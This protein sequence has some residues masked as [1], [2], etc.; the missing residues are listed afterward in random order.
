MSVS[1]V[2]IVSIIGLLSEL[3]KV[4]K[5]CGESQVFHPDNALSFYKNTEKFVPLSDKNPYSAPLSKINEALT[6]AGKSIKTV[7]VHNFDVTTK[8]INDY[9][10]YL[11]KKLGMLS[12]EKSSLLQKIDSINN[13]IKELKHFAEIPVDLKDIYS[14]EYIKAR[15][16]RIPKENFDELNSYSNNP[17]VLFSSCSSDNHYY[18]GV[19]F[20]PIDHVNNVDEIFHSLNFEKVDVSMYK[21]APKIQIQELEDSKKDLIKQLAIIEKK[22]DAFWKV[23]YEQCIRFYS[24]LDE[25]NTYFSIKSYVSKYNNSFILVG[26]IPIENEDEFA[27]KLKNMFGVEFAIENAENELKFSPP[28]KLKNK[29]IFKPFEFFVDM[30]GLPSYDEI[31]PTIFVSIVYT[32]LFGI[33]FGDVGQG[34]VLSIAGYL[35]WKF[36]HMDLGKILIPCGISS[37]VFGFVYG[38]V[39]GLENLLDGFYNKVFGLSEKPIDVMEPNTTMMILVAAISIGVVLIII[40]MLL[41]IISSLKRKNYENA[42]FGPNGLCGLVFYSSLIIGLSIQYTLNIKIITIPYI[43][44]LIILPLICIVL[45]GILGK[46]ILRDKN[47]KPES[48]GDYLLENIFEIFEVLL[49]YL[50][51]TISFLRVGAYVLVHAGMM[52]AVSALASMTSGLAYIIIFVIGNILVI[53]LEGLLVGIQ[54]LRLNFYEIFSRFFEG[55]GRPFNPITIKKV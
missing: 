2:R 34:I 15:F 21:G 18:W 25:L 43:I 39:F 52:L 6:T 22:I 30:Y 36:K 53:S 27:S 54:V 10:D 11:S 12:K 4:I 7:D 45:K 1:A 40:S 33:M 37:A 49:S 32:T 55:E 51:N 26:W 3:D 16:G 31:D 35:M 20:A 38:S 13:S 9:V 17:Y 29:K 50:S 14:C 23:Q 41:N 48:L 46:L 8:Q 28:V 42:L 44:L 5:F 19:Y 47:W 24:K